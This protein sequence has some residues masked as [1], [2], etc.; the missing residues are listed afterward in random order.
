[1]NFNPPDSFK[2]LEHYE[3][4][5]KSCFHSFNPLIKLDIPHKKTPYFCCNTHEGE[6]EE[7]FSSD[8]DCLILSETLETLTFL[9]TPSDLSSMYNKD[10]AST[11]CTEGAPVSLK[12]L[13]YST[14][15]P[16]TFKTLRPSKSS[17]SISHDP[18]IIL[19][20]QTVPKTIQ[21]SDDEGAFQCKFC[22]KI[23]LTGQALGGHMSRRH[24]VI[25]AG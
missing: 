23:F 5:V 18:V 1:M 6:F 8:S 10:E 12:Q 7:S 24:P 2:C 14:I 16:N 21:D 19:P 11:Q 20:R 17:F 25:K 3:S 22:F 9:N 15:T 13:S 4:P